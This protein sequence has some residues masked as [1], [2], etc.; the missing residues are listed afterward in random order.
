MIVIDNYDSF[1]YN[2]VEYLKI[3]EIN[4]I[5]IKND[6]MSI[7]D[8]SKLNFE[9]III[10]PGYGNPNNSG[11]SLEII[12]KYNGLK[13]ILGICLGHQ[14]IAQYFGAKIIK[15]K[16]PYHGKTSKIIYDANSQI[17]KGL[18]QN[19]LATRY[20]SLTVDKKTCQYPIKIT[21]KTEDDIIMGLEIENTKTYGV[22]FH[23]EAILTENGIKIIEN[24]IN[25]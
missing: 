24:F 7:K 13:S 1:T 21:A 11:V 10:S 22:Q 12:Q 19:F 18:K 17:F 9:K 8:I 16:E 15:L 14:C 23:P 5:I 6:E 25:I 4:P 2:I 20:H 3:L